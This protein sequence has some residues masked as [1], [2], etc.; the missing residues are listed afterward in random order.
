ML[1]DNADKTDEFLGLL[2]Q[3]QSY[4]QSYIA[5]LL[6]NKNDCDDVLQ[7]TLSEMWHKFDEYEEGTNFKAWGVAIAR[8]KILSYRRK[9]KTS[10]LHFS[11]DTIEL[12]EKEAERSAD[13]QYMQDQ[14]E[15]L[16]QCLEKLSGKEKKYL[17]FRYKQQLTFQGIAD[18]FGI[19]M[20]GAYKAISLIHARL[21]RCIQSGLKNEGLL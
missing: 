11:S 4:L 14:K 18:H 1:S 15:M 6:P 2:V 8:L 5:C 17:S 19:S 9:Y 3:N 10:R 12:L 20:Q 13:K 7:E 16:Q 21:L